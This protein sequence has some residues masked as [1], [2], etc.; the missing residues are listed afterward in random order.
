MVET[1]IIPYFMAKTDPNAAD[2]V[3]FDFNKINRMGIR[4]KLDVHIYVKEDAIEY[5][6]KILQFVVDDE[7]SVCLPGITIENSE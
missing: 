1:A 3:Y 2:E 7:L 5:K 4:H 6:Y